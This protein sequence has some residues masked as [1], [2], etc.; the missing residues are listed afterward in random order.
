MPVPVAASVIRVLPYSGGLLPPVGEIKV[1]ELRIAVWTSVCVTVAVEV[2]VTVLLPYP[3]GGEQAQV[4]GSASRRPILG[5]ALVMPTM[6]VAAMMEAR[7]FM[8]NETVLELWCKMLLWLQCEAPGLKTVDWSSRRKRMAKQA[9]RAKRMC[10][11][12]TQR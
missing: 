12:A 8:L 11:D 6:P 10:R 5:A 1:P 9:H 7:Y 3:P 2:S 4:K